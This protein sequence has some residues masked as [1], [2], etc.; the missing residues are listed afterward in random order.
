MPIYSYICNSCGKEF[1][2]LVGIKA[3]P[4]GLKCSFCSS[5]N[6]K[7]IF[8]AFGISVSSKGTG[9]GGS[10]SSCSKQNCSAFG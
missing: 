9:S 10:C 1:D 6:I 4:K 7:K 5:S 3:D 2:L 8:A